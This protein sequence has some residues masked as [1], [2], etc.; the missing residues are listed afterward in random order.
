MRNKVAALIVFI[1][2]PIAVFSTTK[3][4][5]TLEF[6][7]VSSKLKVHNNGGPVF[8]YTSVIFAQVGG[9]DVVFWCAQKGD[10]CPL[11]ET[12]KT[13]T[14]ERDGDVIYVPMSFPDDQHPL[15]VKYKQFR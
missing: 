5:G 10:L 11:M 12:G 14:A 3:E 4:R 8:T 7:V 13:Y 9:M 15:R 6:K 1:L 2:L